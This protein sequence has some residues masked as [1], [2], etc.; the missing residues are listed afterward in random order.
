MRDALRS[1][2]VLAAALAAVAA[3]QEAAPPA[4]K[5]SLNI[6]LSLTEGNSDTRVVNA[7]LLTEGERPQLG[8]IRAGLEANYGEA[9]VNGVYEKT[10]ENAR[11]FAN[12]RKTLT[13]RTFASADVS[14]L[15]DDV[16]RIAYR[17]MVGPGAGAYVI[18][19]D[20][21][22]LSAEIG[23]SYVW[24]KQA[25]VRDDFLAVRFAETFSHQLS[26]TAKIWQS[27]EVIPQFED[28]SVFLLK[29]EIGVEAAINTRLSLRVTVRDQY[30]SDPA[31]DTEKN[32]VSLIAGVSLR[33]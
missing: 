2:A 29:A 12:A 19:D 20:R 31:P 8:S 33:W 18:K 13:E 17:V 28:F 4:M 32:D 5:N 26:A 27:V 9:R 30:D 16:A 24:E 25:G 10:V 14:A 15:H 22:S 6:G 23:L 11:G 1:L 3:A 21:T 7:A